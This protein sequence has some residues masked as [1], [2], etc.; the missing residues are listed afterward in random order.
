MVI[1]SSNQLKNITSLIEYVENNEFF[2]LKA[3]EIENLEVIMN[4]IK[5]KLRLKLSR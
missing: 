5:F 4:D 3:F 2:K 1:T